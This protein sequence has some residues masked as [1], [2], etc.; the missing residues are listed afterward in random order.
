MVG[1]AFTLMLNWS[2][3]LVDERAAA[4]GAWLAA[5]AEE[6]AQA[7]AAGRSATHTL[8]PQMVANEAASEVLQAIGRLRLAL[9]TDFGRLP[10]FEAD[11]EDAAHTV[12]RRLAAQARA[13]GLCDA[14]R[15][16]WVDA[17]V[18]AFLRTSLINALRDVGR[19]GKHRGDSV[20]GNGAIENRD[21]EAPP[22]ELPAP[23]DQM[24]A[25]LEVDIARAESR[26]AA[27]FERYCE[28]VAPTVRARLERLM[29][30]G[31]EGTTLT[32]WVERENQSATG[33]ALATLKDTTT[34]QHARARAALQ[35]WIE[36]LPAP[37]HTDPDDLMAEDRAR[38]LLVRRLYLHAPPRPVPT[39][40]A[41]TAQHEKSR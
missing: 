3:L 36:D 13:A 18:M 25:E 35:A 16:D 30:L 4:H 8:P 33:D 22:R 9:R 6:K 2:A 14:H 15:S 37:A 21:P 23:N 12:I 39:P 17:E 11:F 31:C 27:L 41:S 5:E 34:R 40:A 38:R 32:D 24:S 1:R 28:R 19:A 10:D 29:A 26:A 7:K 20:D